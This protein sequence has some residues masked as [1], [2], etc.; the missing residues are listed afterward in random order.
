MK[1]KQLMALALI[2]FAVGACKRPDGGDSDVVE[3]EG[4]VV[5]AKLAINVPKSIRT[6]APGDGDP[7]ATV[8]EKVA[9]YI[10]VFIYEDG[11]SYALS[12]YGRFTPNGTPPT[13]AIP[14]GTQFGIDN[15]TQTQFVTADFDV[16]EGEK[17][18][19]VGINLPDLIVD[20]LKT[21]YYVNETFEQTD[22]INLLA[23]EQEIGGSSEVAF[24]NTA[25]VPHDLTADDEI[26]N[27]SVSRLIAKVVVMAEDADDDISGGSNDASWDING[28]TVSELEFA[29]GQRNNQMFVSPLVGGADPNYGVSN[30][31]TVGEV[32]PNSIVKLRPVDAVND[33]IVVNDI[34]PIANVALSTTNMRYTTENTSDLHRHQD[35]TYVSIKAKFAPHR[36]DP[37]PTTGKLP[38]DG[39]PNNMTPPTAGFYAVFTGD[40][41][42]EDGVGV[43]YFNA[44][45]ADGLEKARN[46][47]MGD[48]F[49]DIANGGT[50]ITFP[51]D[52]AT[53]PFDNAAA[54]ATADHYIH[55]YDESNCYYR[56]YLNPSEVDG[57]TAPGLGGYN[58]FRN[59]VYIARVT[60]VNY[61][62]TT[63]PDI[64][65]GSVDGNGKGT[66][67]YPGAWFPNFLAAPVQQ[68][69]VITPLDLITGLSVS[70]T[71]EDWKD[72][73]QDYEVN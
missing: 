44:D 1:L 36:F 37:D 62:G 5:K 58:I 28:G 55:F 46:F 61:I 32:S 4:K 65:P 7:L 18:V 63:E 72:D 45:D 38:D 54:T 52:P 8:D 53:D 47:V 60:G 19:F 13:V 59:T 39:S 49:A 29:I 64:L 17:L 35:V 66:P 57:A 50:N 23:N 33:Y 48:Y 21:G 9:N 42:G 14:T 15:A 70:V 41:D 6:Y 68:S 2:G 22:L 10:D 30:I 51:G 20:R 26:L 27:V 56:I 71:M 40:P 3:P 16:R 31:N 25:L 34:G 73:D 11:G 12:F 67:T 43:R 24:F 69:D